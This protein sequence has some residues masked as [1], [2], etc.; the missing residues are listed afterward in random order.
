[1]YGDAIGN[2]DRRW[3]AAAS[4]FP[5]IAKIRDDLFALSSVLAFI[6]CVTLL[7]TKSFSKSR[8]LAEDM[9]LEFFSLYFGSD[10]KVQSFA[11]PLILSGQDEAARR[12]NIL[13]SVLGDS[14][15]PE[16]IIRRVVNDFHFR[17]FFGGAGNFNEKSEFTR[18]AE[19]VR[20]CGYVDVA[21]ELVGKVGYRVADVRG[22]IFSKAKV[23][24]FRDESI[25][26][27]FCDCDEFVGWVKLDICD[28]FLRK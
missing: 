3:A 19:E 16:L 18:L 12:L 23:V 14:A 28:R 4:V 24:V 9:E 27:E 2:F 25:A 11:K 8:K 22:G 17:D 10:V 21:K 20:K 15:D 26:M 5:E 13:V 1:M 7:E 6:Y